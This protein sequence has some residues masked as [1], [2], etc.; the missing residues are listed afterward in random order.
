MPPEDYFLTRRLTAFAHMA[1]VAALALAFAVAAAAAVVVEGPVAF[2]TAHV[3]CCWAACCII[4]SSLRIQ[5]W[6]V[7]FCF[8]D[9]LFF[10]FFFEEGL[11]E[12][13][14]QQ[15]RLQLAALY[16]CIP[17]RASEAGLSELPEYLVLAD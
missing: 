15:I 14:F 10:A 13:A 5:H 6:T 7:R 16:S 2:V 1:L 17:E 12:G 3:R 11:V 9:R 8:F 4:F